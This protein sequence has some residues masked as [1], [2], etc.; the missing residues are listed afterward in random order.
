MG[1][2]IK[3]PA[4]LKFCVEIHFCT[5]N[6]TD[7]VA[8]PRCSHCSLPFIRYMKAVFSHISKLTSQC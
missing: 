2:N 1:V 4:M 3:C 8:G 7:Y 5:W 6:P